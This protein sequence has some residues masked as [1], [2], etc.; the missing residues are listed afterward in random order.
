MLASRRIPLSSVAGNGVARDSLRGSCDENSPIGRFK[1][2]ASTR[3]FDSATRIAS[4]PAS[5]AQDD[6]GREMSAAI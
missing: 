6:L 1:M 3:S 4:D 2:R 5:S